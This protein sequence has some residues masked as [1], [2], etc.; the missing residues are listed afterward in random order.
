[1]VLVSERVLSV[2]VSE[3]EHYLRKKNGNN[4]QQIILKSSVRLARNRVKRYLRECVHLGV[5]TSILS[6]FFLFYWTKSFASNDDEILK[7][8]KTDYK[9][10]QANYP[11]I[12]YLRK[13]IVRLCKKRNIRSPTKTEK[14]IMKVDQ[15][16][17][18]LQQ[19]SL[20]EKSIQYKMN[21]F[22][23]RNRCA[24]F[25]LSPLFCFEL[26]FS[27]LTFSVVIAKKKQKYGFKNER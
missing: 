12:K 26:I 14:K 8:H 6:D 2:S 4:Q 10:T 21:F 22:G 11:T 17:A 9:N 15:L 19:L 5:G 1:M 25:K 7:L 23:A 20:K 27:I 18:N 16:R 3:R 24:N 13:T